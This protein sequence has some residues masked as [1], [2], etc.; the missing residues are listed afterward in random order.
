[1]LLEAEV[2]TP[3]SYAGVKKTIKRQ[4][5]GRRPPGQ[6][7]SPSSTPLSFQRKHVSGLL[8]SCLPGAARPLQPGGGG[9][10]KS[11]LRL[12]RRQG[13]RLC[14]EAS[15]RGGCVQTGTPTPH[16]H[17]TRD[18][19]RTGDCRSV[20]Q[21]RYA[22][23]SH[24]GIGPSPVKQGTGIVVLLIPT[25]ARL[26]HLPLGH[27]LLPTPPPH[28]QGSHAPQRVNTA[29]LMVFSLSRVRCGCAALT[30][31]A[32]GQCRAPR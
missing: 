22:A 32:T 11:W 5:E 27:C 17:R 21:S 26:E 12:L 2:L 4:Q 10:Q 18:R 19:G 15:G 25:P 3:H 6:P 24:G 29:E 8:G 30:S 9:A 1:M 16:A 28:D 23:R 20:I 7:A 31:A 14:T 13:G